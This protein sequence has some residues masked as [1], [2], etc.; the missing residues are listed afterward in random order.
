[1]PMFITCTKN[2]VNTPFQTDETIMLV[3][4]LSDLS[5]LPTI[6]K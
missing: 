1:M 4:T 5:I 2:L 3:I 6:A